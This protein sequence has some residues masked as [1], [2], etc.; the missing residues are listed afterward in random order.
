MTRSLRSSLA[1][2]FGEGSATAH[3]ALED[4]QGIAV[5]IVILALSVGL[6]EELGLLTSGIAGLAL[7]VHF[8]TGVPT[9][10][11]FFVLNLPFYG[12]AILRL[13]WRF[14][15]K[16]VAAVAALSVL[17][18]QQDRLITFEWVDPV[19][20]A[21]LSGLL[22]G[23]GLLAMFRHRAS[24]GGIGILAVWL[25]DR[26]GI[27]AGITQLVHDT[28]LF[29]VALI[30]LPSGAVALSFL[31]AIVLNLFLTVNHRPDRYIAR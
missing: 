13:G 6:L 10:V 31:S 11:A 30:V 12:L 26:Y 1:R 8:A 23:F 20:G 16:T 15:A 17:L 4:A 18:D 3:S 5:A 25:Q 21:I 9:G 19:Y 28:L 14:T 29:T 2:H 22:I 7:I 27:R 24:V